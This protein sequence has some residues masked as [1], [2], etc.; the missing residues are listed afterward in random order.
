EAACD[1]RVLD[2]VDGRDRAS[3]GAAIAKAAT[4][5]TLLFAG[6]L[7]RPS[8]LSRRLTIMA[9]AI[10]RNTRTIG[11]GL[12]GGAVLAALPLTATWAVVYVDAGDSAAPAPSAPVQ[13]VA[14]AQTVAVS[15]PI[16]A[17]LAPSAALAPA[18]APG[19]SMHTDSDGSLVLPG[20]VKLDK[21]STAFFDDDR[22][23]IN[24]KVMRLDQ[25]T[26][27]ERSELRAAIAKSLRS[28]ERER[29]QLPRHLAAARRELERIRNGDLK[30][31]ILGDREDLRRDLAEIVAEAAELRANGEDPEKR[32]AEILKDLREAEA[33]DID[34]EIRQ[35][36]EEVNPDKIIAELRNDE[37]QMKRMQA[38]LDQLDRAD[39]Q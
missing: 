34:K 6:A 20:G 29:A 32:K 39:N 11:F 1:A 12:V 15:A 9:H 19:P 7:D 2:K 5:R 28:L 27:A 4:G 24:G 13:P 18:A 16:T 26:R 23:F 30:R 37:E 36:I 22:V 8:T 21:G 31:E 3:Y 10:P 14:R 17:A 35:A 25:A 38:R 33:I